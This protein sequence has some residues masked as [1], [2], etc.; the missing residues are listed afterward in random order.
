LVAGVGRL[1]YEG[2]DLGDVVVEDEVVLRHRVEVHASGMIPSR[3]FGTPMTVCNRSSWARMM[4]GGHGSHRSTGSHLDPIG[5]L[6]TWRFSIPW[7]GREPSERVTEIE[8]A[9]SAWEPAPAGDGLAPICGRWSLTRPRPTCFGPAVWPVCGP[10]PLG[11]RGYGLFEQASARTRLLVSLGRSDL[12]LAADLVGSGCDGEESPGGGYAF[13]FVLAAVVECRARTCDEVDDGS[14]YEY[15]AGLC[16]FADATCEVDG[17]A[18]QLGATSFDFT[19][20]D[21]DPYVEADLA[22]G[23]ADRGPTTDRAGGAVEGG[24]YA[25]TGESLFVA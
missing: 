15:L 22:S 4:F 11:S 6:A 8:P 24:E 25:V 20:V 10:G 23:V 1:A 17:D 19:G 3:T 5:G 7:P 18:R 13:E 14:G 16:G 21:P 2:L 12:A 9:L